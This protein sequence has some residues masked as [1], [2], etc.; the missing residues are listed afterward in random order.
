VRYVVRDWLAKLCI[1]AAGLAITTVAPVSLD[2]LPDVIKLL[3]VG[4]EPRRLASNEASRVRR[5]A[6]PPGAVRSAD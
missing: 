5:S 1:V 3:A 4:G 2:G 6:A